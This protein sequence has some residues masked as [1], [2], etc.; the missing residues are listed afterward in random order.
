MSSSETRDALLRAFVESDVSPDGKWW[1]DVP[2]GLSVGDEEAYAVVDGVCL[3][4]RTLE[5][6]EVYPEHTGVPYVVHR[7]DQEAGVTKVDT[8]R[9]LRRR[10]T[11][12]EE[13]AVIVA[14]DPGASS[15]G[16]VGNLLAYRELLEADWDWEIEE[17]L[18]V[19]DEDS[20]HVNHVC[21]ELGV[22]AM[23]VA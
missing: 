17:L 18:L 19:S 11:F 20:D 6:P 5:L 9:T 3:T 13:T 7:G 16:A 10:D 23:R 1:L 2:V 15:V 14:V 4:S 8:F 22:R 21:R 12:A